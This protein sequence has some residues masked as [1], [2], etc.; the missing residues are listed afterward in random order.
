MKRDRD[1]PKKD[2]Q[3]IDLRVYHGVVTWGLT[4]I[5]KR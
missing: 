4:K 3:E 5:M 2:S 1:E